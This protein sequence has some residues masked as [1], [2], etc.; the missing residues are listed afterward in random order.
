MV[1]FISFVFKSEHDNF[2]VS[3]YKKFSIMNTSYQL[4]KD[5]GNMDIYRHKKY[6]NILNFTLKYIRIL[7]KIMFIWGDTEKF[8]A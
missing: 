3:F 4:L 6:L 5:T 1:I 8:S 2:T 7:Y